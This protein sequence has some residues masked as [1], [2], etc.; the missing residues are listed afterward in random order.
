MGL[1]SFSLWSNIHFADPEK[2]QLLVLVVVLIVLGLLAWGFKTSYRPAPTYGSRYPLL[3]KAKFILCLIVAL[4]L[5]I[6]AYARPYL[7]RGNIIVKKGNVEVVVLVD[8]SGSMLLQDT[9]WA[10]IDI[11]VREVSKLPALDILKD[12]DRVSL[13]ILGNMGMR[14][15]PMTKDVSTFATEISRLGRP[16]DF[17][18]DNIY[19][20]SDVGSAFETLYNSVDRQDMFV[21]FGTKEPTNW[22]PKVKQNRL[23]IFFSDGDFF[24]YDD[25]DEAESAVDDKKN[26]DSA[27]LELRKRGLKVY[28]VGIGT[29]TG[30]QLSDVLN[31][32]RINEEYDPQLAKDLEG[33]AS[34]LNPQ[35]LDYIRNATGAERMTTLENSNSDSSSFLRMVIDGHRNMSIEPG[36]ITEKEDMYVYFSVAALLVFAFG[37]AITKF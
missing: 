31:D 23:V 18:G 17:L 37:M 13:F 12:G 35:H 15:L 24:N 21:E 34:R 6:M 3:G 8:T 11:A 33:Q 25:K 28:P 10:R 2:L 30:A 16:K 5:L 22:R 19:W 20:G 1:G 14:R 26:L 36:M 4:A 7:E 29:R 9:G 32:Y 27:L